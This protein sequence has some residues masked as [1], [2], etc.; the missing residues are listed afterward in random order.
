MIPATSD[1]G[2]G[3]SQVQGLPGLQC[4]MGQ[5]MKLSKTL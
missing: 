3:G 2:A 1:A 4:L 5:P